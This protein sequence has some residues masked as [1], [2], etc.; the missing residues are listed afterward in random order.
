MTT[1]Y[2]YDAPLSEAGDPTEKLFAIRTVISK[3]LSLTGGGAVL[4]SAACPGKREQRGA[5]QG[6]LCAHSKGSL[7]PVGH[8]TVCCS[9]PAPAS[10]PDAT[11]HP[12]VRLW[13]GGSAQGE[14]LPQGLC[15]P[16]WPYLAAQLPSLSLQY[17]DFLDVLDVLSPSG[18]I[19]SQFPLTF[20]AVKQVG[21]LRVT[22]G[23]TLGWKNG[24]HRQPYFPFCAAWQAHGFMLYRTQLPY[25]ILAPATLSAPPHSICDRGYV[26][27]QKVREQ[28]CLP[29][30]RGVL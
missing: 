5:G 25:D 3:V 28:G 11:P 1:S 7:S 26:M 30:G 2:D 4:R 27:L 23:D 19:Q 20:E 16:A 12:Q 17:A 6:H 29:L 24:A 14:C 22:G 21:A 10:G 9:V 8:L 15:C 18:P 13:P